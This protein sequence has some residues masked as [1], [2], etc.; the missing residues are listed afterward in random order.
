[1]AGNCPINFM[2]IVFMLPFNIKGKAQNTGMNSFVFCQ[3]LT[4]ALSRASILFLEKLL[5][6]SCV[7]QKSDLVWI[8]AFV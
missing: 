6:H 7:L 5:L 8:L 1:M 2:L 3:L 4:L